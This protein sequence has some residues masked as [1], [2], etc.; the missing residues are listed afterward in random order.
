METIINV[1]LPIFAIMALGYGCGYWGILGQEATA[2]LNKFVYLVA[3]PP[4]MFTFTAR[5]QIDEIFNWGFVGTL[6]LGSGLT[7]VL[8][9]LAAVIFF[10]CDLSR[11]AF[12]GFMSVFANYG[13][14]G[15]PVFLAAFGPEGVLPAIVSSFVAAIPAMLFIMIVLEVKRPGGNSSLAAGI[16]RIFL[17][18]PLFL[19][20]L[21]G[22]LFSLF[23]LPIPKSVG[24]L[25]DMLTAA[26]AP[27]ALFALGLSLVAYSILGD[28]YE[29]AWM[30]FLKLIVHPVITFFLASEVFHLSPFWA[31][32]AVLLTAMPVGSTAY[33]IAQQYGVAERVSSASIAI[34]TAASV[35]TLTALMIYYGV[36]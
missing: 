15:I 29:V 31:A 20:T 16:W 21:A 22:I 1:T 4:A 25:L 13:Y 27:T 33:L 32:S 3:L 12:H 36:S 7:I 2:G 18:N 11:S 6:L 19:A 8:A 24:A 5:A 23:E 17:H 14:M 10:K 9:V 35:I 34:S 28:I 30:T 26:A